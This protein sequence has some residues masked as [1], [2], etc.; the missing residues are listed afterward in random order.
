VRG[1]SR[2]CTARGSP[3]AQESTHDA[4]K[5]LGASRPCILALDGEVSNST[6]AEEFAKAY[7]NHYFEMFVAERQKVAA[8]VTPTFVAGRCPWTV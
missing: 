2:P 8:P 3:E 6:R 7:P 1:S 4:L 5:A